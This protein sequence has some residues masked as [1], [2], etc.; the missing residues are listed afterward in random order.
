LF[1]Y[2]WHLQNNGQ[3]VFGDT[4]PVRG[5]DLDM[6]GLHT[7]GVRGKGVIVGVID[8]GLEIRHEDLK[9]NV[10]PGGSKNFVDGSNDPTPIKG[11]EAAAHGT[12]VAGIIAAV[13]WNGKGVRGVAPEA[14]LKGFNVLSEDFPPPQLGDENAGEQQNINTRYS[15]GDGFESKDVDVFNNS[16]G[17]EGPGYPSV[18]LA[19]VRSWERLMASTR[20][21]KGGIYLKA[22]GNEFADY[23]SDGKNICTDPRTKKLQLSCISASTDPINS[24]IGVIT[25]ASVNASGVRSSYS[26]AGS[27]L[28]VSGL[29]GEY[30]LQ[31]AYLPPKAKQFPPVYFE[32]AIVTTDLSGCDRGKNQNDQ[33][34]NALATSRSKIDSSCNYTA[35][36]NGTSAAAPTVAGVAA[37]MLGVNPNLTQRDVKYILAS[38]ARQIDAAQPKAIY[39]GFVVDPGWITNAAGHHFSNWYGFGLVD[40]MAAVKMA[41]S[42]KSLPPMRDSGWQFSDSGDVKIQGARS[43]EPAELGVTIDQKFKVEAVQF[44]FRT[45]HKTPSNLMA[46]LISPSGTK[47]YVQTPFSALEPLEASDMGFEVSLAASNAFLDESAQGTWKL[48]VIDVADPKVQAKLYDFKIRIVGH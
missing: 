40:A 4:L 43:P 19:E 32:P 26:N 25:V 5:V 29:G 34:Y 22:A 15:W 27:S 38:T 10:V 3:P 8:S 18:A 1:K 35:T 13:G 24:Y 30:G 28:W 12:A 11:S 37:L 48:Q 7:W 39:E 9:D 44:S 46:V 20:K 16:W 42:F 47:S 33:P 23:Q 14:R 2:Q 17:S 41:G 36:M 45:T 21:G 31:K 6:G